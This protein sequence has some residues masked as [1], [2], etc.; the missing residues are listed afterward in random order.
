MFR[1]KVIRIAHLNQQIAKLF[2]IPLIK[3]YLFNFP[4]GVKT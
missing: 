4:P 1:S 3:L 2:N